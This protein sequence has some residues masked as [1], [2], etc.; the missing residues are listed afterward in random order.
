MVRTQGEI[1]KFLK[2]FACVSL[3]PLV[4]TIALCVYK[5]LPSEQLWVF[6]LNLEGGFLLSFTIAPTEG[7]YNNFREWFIW[8]FSESMGYASPVVYNFAFFY[9]GLICFV[10][11]QVIA[12]FK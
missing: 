5:H 7:A 9:L 2:S 4:A 10:T 3:V 6:F 8:F 12:G 11:A 1:L